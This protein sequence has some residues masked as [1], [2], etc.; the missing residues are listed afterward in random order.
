MS[1]TS[2]EKAKIVCEA[3]SSF[4]GGEFTVFSNFVVQV[5]FLLL[6]VLGGRTRVVRN[7][8]LLVVFILA[9][10]VRR[11]GLT[12]RLVGLLLLRRLTTA[13][14]TMSL[15]FSFPIATVDGLS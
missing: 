7:K 14:F 5:Q 1:Y 2:A 6:G 10:L 3:T 11:G 8:Q 12:L 4:H 9:A 15:F 13:T